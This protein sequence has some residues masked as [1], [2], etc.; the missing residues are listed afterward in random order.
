MYASPVLPNNAPLGLDMPGSIKQR[1][2]LLKSTLDAAVPLWILA[3]YSRGGPT[4][5]DY[6][7]ASDGLEALGDHGDVLLFGSGKPGQVAKMF[8]VLAKSIAI[9]SFSPGGVTVFDRHWDAAEITSRFK[10][11]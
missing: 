9:L 7:W 1:E 3:I 5:E 8:N 4:K 6:E 11:P 2:E 10:L